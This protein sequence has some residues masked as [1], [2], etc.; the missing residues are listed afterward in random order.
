MTIPGRNSTGH[1]GD[2]HTILR[3][4]DCSSSDIIDFS[5]NINPLGP[6]EWTRSLISREVENIEHYPDPYY[7]ELRTAISHRLNIPVEQ[8]AV[9]NGS[10]DLLYCLPKVLGCKRAVIPVPSY[11]DYEKAARQAQLD[12]HFFPLNEEENFQL[13]PTRLGECITASDLV[14]FA[15]PNN[16]TGMTVSAEDIVK[17]ADEHREAWF[18]I[19]EAFLDFVAEGQSVAALA[20]NILTINSMTK[21]YGIPGLRLGYGVFPAGITAKL[22]DILPTWGVNSIAQAFGT[23]ALSDRYYFERTVK[24]VTRLRE[25]LHAK[26]NQ[27]PQLKVYPGSANYLFVKI[28]DSTSSASLSEKLF[29]QGILIRCCDNYQN[30][31]E[32][33]FR[34]AVRREEE[35]DRLIEALESIYQTQKKSAGKTKKTPALMFQGTSSN[36]GKSILTAAFCRILLQDGVNVAPFK[37]QNMSLNSF[38]TLKGEEM[39]RAQVVQAQAAKLDPD[40]RMNP[41]LLKPNSDTGSQI[42][43]NGYPIGNMSVYEYDSYKDNGGW[44]AV[45][46]SYMSLASENDA[47]LLEGAG[48]PGEVNLKKM[49]IV[50]MRMAGFAEAPVLLVGDID[51]GG[52]YASFIGTMEVLEEWERRLVAGF[53]VNRFRGQ[54][55]LLQSA[56]DYVMNHTGKPVMGV[57]PYIKDHGLPEEDS[58]SFKSGLF[59]RGAVEKEY[60]DIVLISLPHIS[61]FTDVEALL[62]EP[63]VQLRV[64]DNPDE[65]GDPD[66]II[67]PGSKNVIGDLRFLLDKGFKDILYTKRSEGCQLVGICGGYIMLGGKITDPLKLESE[68]TEFDGLAM[69]DITTELKA[70]KQLIRR[71]G[72]HLQS[73]ETVTGYEIHHGISQSSLEPCLEFS[74]GSFCGS[75]QEKGNVWGAYLHGIFDSDGFRRW[76]IDELRIKKGFAPHKQVLVPYNLESAFDNVAD[77]V[78]QSV[79]MDEIYKLLK[80]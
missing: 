71:E 61:N 70:E 78:R 5:A 1:G 10:T 77:I 79:D 2:I 74:D 26:L 21:F 46:E 33:Y 45:K 43:V 57:I 17:L 63:D 11:I 47:I 59:N 49:D 55:S 58:V 65:L 67:L 23:R 18:L 73:G 12:I 52:I 69:L 9:A 42:I 53:L 35:N 54:Q 6:P 3:E 66:C 50:N 19:D 80:L 38:V 24:T 4:I 22:M 7:T 64:I 51:R 27:F 25:E 40:A 75:R 31:G 36:A 39:G 8:V 48:S 72:T 15:S 60:V 56:H 62:A 28:V 32:A 13:N 30:L 76:F 37:A 44:D 68:L 16:P 34:V 29:K 20:G 41:I 14:I